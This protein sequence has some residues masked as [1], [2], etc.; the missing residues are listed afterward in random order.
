M[1]HIGRAGS[2]LVYFALSALF[3]CALLWAG[4]C[5]AASNTKGVAFWIVARFLLSIVVSCVW[6]LTK[7]AGEGSIQ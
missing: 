3:W 4:V 5:A 7:A 2:H 6:T 1:S